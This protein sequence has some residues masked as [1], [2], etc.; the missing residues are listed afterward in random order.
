MGKLQKEVERIT[1]EYEKLRSHVGRIKQK[2][3]KSTPRKKQQK[4]VDMSIQISPVNQTM[5]SPEPDYK[6]TLKVE[7]LKQTRQTQDNW[8]PRHYEEKP[9]FN[10]SG[11]KY[12]QSPN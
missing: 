6:D 9:T 8:K 2:T 4:E 12:A 7:D 5:G 11:L 3:D 10:P 1:S